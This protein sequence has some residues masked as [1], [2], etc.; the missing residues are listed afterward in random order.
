[1]VKAI[2]QLQNAIPNNAD[3]LCLF[4]GS[5]VPLAR[6][7]SHI[8]FITGARLLR[9]MVPAG[10]LSGEA[11]DLCMEFVQVDDDIII[12]CICNVPC[13]LVLLEP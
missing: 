9:L 4:V 13:A 3:T 11:V 10:C 6:V 8:S 2:G 7:A 1:M 12:S 5:T